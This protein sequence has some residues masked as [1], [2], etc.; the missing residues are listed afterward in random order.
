V[1]IHLDKAKGKGA[2]AILILNNANEIAKC[3]VV[4]NADKKLAKQR[5]IDTKNYRTVSGWPFSRM[6]YNEFIFTTTEA[7]VLC[8]ALRTAI[9]SA[10][11]GKEAHVPSV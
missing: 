8:D 2:C 9:K 10:Q 4:Q 1:K 3:V 7:L 11:I 5:K 6:G